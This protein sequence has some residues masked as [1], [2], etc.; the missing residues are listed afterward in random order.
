MIENT[1][2]LN[3]KDDESSHDQIKMTEFWLYYD[4]KKFTWT[5][6]PVGT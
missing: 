1:Y 3:L 2:I 6:L 4:R 5:N